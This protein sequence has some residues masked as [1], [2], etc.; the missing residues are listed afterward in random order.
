MR[1]ETPFAPSLPRRNVANNPETSMLRRSQAMPPLQPD[2]VPRAFRTCALVGNG[3][4]VRNVRNGEAIDKHDAVF[5]F[6]A[7]RRDEDSEFTG[8]SDPRIAID[9]S[10]S[11]PSLS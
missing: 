6:N 3:P 2:E 11:M 1:L 10:I 7:M 9:K 8:A 4:G 5:R